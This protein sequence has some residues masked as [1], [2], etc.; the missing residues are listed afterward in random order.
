MTALTSEQAG[1]PGSCWGGTEGLSGACLGLLIVTCPTCH[2]G[3][4]SWCLGWYGSIDHQ[5]PGRYEA[6]HAL[7]M[8]ALITT[9][10]ANSPAPSTISETQRCR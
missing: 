8:P 3:P 5:H 6:W 2:A 1:S 10:P 9:E 4:G 7:G